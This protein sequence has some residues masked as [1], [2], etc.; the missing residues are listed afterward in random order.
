MIHETYFTHHKGG[1]RDGIAP[2][3]EAVFIMRSKSQVLSPSWN[4][5]KDWK[6]C[7][8]NKMAWRDYTQR[9]L[10][11]M[12]SDEAKAEIKR[13]SDLSHTKDI[14]LV[15]S[16]YNARKECHRFIVLDLIR[17]A[18]GLIDEN[19]LSGLESYAPP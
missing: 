17:Q 12:E 4:L 18:G 9:F 13:L 14:W 19:A 11:E 5:L 2:Q 6:N 7:T 8:K 1:W 10:E 3:G 16:C 15:C